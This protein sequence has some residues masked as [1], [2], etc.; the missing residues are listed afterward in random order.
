MQSGFFDDLLKEEN[1]NVETNN[2]NE[3]P[4]ESAGANNND[5]EEIN[6]GSFSFENGNS[7]ENNKIG[8]EKVVENTPNPTKTTQNFDFNT[9]KAETPIEEKKVEE[10]PKNENKVK[11]PKN[12]AVEQ[13]VENKPTKIQAPV[14]KD[15]SQQLIE[16]ML[17]KISDVVTY[18]NETFTPQAKVIACD[19]ITSIDHTIN[20]RGYRWNEIDAKGSGLVMQIKKWA[21]LGVDCSTDKLYAD[22]RKNG[23]TGMY[24]IKVKGQY[25]TVERL[26]ILYCKKNIIK[27]KTEVIC[28]GDKLETRFNYET[29]EEK[30]IDFKKNDSIN[31]NDINNIIGAF[32]IAYLE[33]EKGNRSQLVTIIEKDRISRAM[34]AAKTKNVWTSD[35]QKMVKKTVTWEMFNGEDI[36]PFMDYPAEIIEDLK[37]VNEN[38]DVDFNKEHKYENVVNADL[39]ATETLGSG[40]E[41]GFN[42]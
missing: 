15:F 4:I 28:I 10:K 18:S 17:T 13:K 1:N 23:N 42:D 7:N 37:I 31:R 20:E 26:M 38:E 22:I 34:Q 12:D 5:V 6:F 21:K 41:V 35:T 11:Q 27:F 3:T 16:N 33:D 9:K 32:K 24:D 25:Q 8:N 40:E 29:G 30:V 14:K 19:I 2:A 36:R 39:H